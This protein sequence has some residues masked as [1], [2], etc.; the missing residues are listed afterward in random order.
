MIYGIHAIIGFPEKAGGDYFISSAVIDDEGRTI[1]VYR[2]THLFGQKKNYFQQ[3]NKYQVVTTKFGKWGIMI[4]YD[5]EFPEVPRILKLKGA[6]IIAILTANMYPYEDYQRVY[7]RSR[8][9]E[10]E[11]PIA[12]CNRLGKEGGLEFIGNSMA[13][14]AQGDILMDMQKIQGVDLLGSRIDR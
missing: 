12:I 9:M 1:D 7:V 10:N 4:C 6:E 3:G 14:N 13:V 11:I 8:V 2:K 5:L